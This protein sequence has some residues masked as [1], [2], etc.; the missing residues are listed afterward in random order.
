MMLP[1]NRP[2]TRAEFERKF[3][4]LSE[5]LRN[6]RVAFG[7][8]VMSSVESLTAVRTLPN[9]RI[10]FLSVDEFARVTVNTMAE[11]PLCQNPL[12]S[13]AEASEQGT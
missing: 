12:P 2:T 10:D 4:L 7:P 5:M 6:E 13:V 8:G 3:H 11:E 9:G 1:M